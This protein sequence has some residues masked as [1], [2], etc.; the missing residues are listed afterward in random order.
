MFFGRER[1]IV[2]EAYPGDILGLINP[3]SSGSATC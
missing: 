1:Q 2:D 3:A